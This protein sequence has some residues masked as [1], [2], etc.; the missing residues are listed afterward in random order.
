MTSRPC[1]DCFRV[2]RCTLHARDDG[3]IA[4][5]CGPCARRLG[6]ITPPTSAARTP[7]KGARRR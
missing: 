1:D 5:L 3:R 6:Y 2:K 7:K 4:Y